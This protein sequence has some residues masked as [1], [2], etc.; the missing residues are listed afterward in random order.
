MNGQSVEQHVLVCCVEQAPKL[1]DDPPI[2]PSAV[3]SERSLVSLLHL[4]VV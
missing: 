1:F 2:H 4:Y 3:V